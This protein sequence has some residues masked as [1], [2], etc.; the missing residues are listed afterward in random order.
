MNR[1]WVKMSQDSYRASQMLHANAIYR[2]AVS[3]AYYCGYAALVAI[4]SDVKGVRFGHGGNNPSHETLASL[5]KNLDDRIYGKMR[6]KWMLQAIRR[7]RAARVLSDYGPNAVIEYE[8]ATRCIKDAAFMVTTLGIL[9]T[10][11]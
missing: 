1:K 8:E 5:V 6:K 11:S 3:R 2:S 4:L 7:L 10:T 9:G